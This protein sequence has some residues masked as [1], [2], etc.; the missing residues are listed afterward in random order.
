MKEISLNKTVYELCNH[1]PE[2]IEVMKEIGFVNITKPGMLQSAGRVMTIPKG[3]RARGV[4]LD[5]VVE[6][7][8]SYG[9]RV[10]GH[11]QKGGKE[12]E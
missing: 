2:F 4:D 5:D 7:I 8:E 12:N 11:S 10:T 9:Y 6:K 3:C 1:D